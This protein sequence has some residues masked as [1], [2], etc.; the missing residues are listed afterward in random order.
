MNS[1][2][3]CHSKAHHTVLT[4]LKASA[5]SLQEQHALLYTVCRPSW[6]HA[7]SVSMM[8]YI[9]PPEPP[10]PTQK[11]IPPFTNIPRTQ[12]L[13]AFCTKFCNFHLPIIKERARACVCVCMSFAGGR[14]VAHHDVFYCSTTG[15]GGER[16]RAAFTFRFIFV[17]CVVKWPGPEC[18]RVCE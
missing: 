1:S 4:H 9:S 11:K 6:A 13:L 2:A 10:S 3:K 12:C 18:P 14:F 5:R 17:P 7:H 16:A 15:G 8:P